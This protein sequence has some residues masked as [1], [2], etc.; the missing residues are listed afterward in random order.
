MEPE[1]VSPAVSELFDASMYTYYGCGS[2][3]NII[4][5]QK[6]PPVKRFHSQS[7][8]ANRVKIMSLK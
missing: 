1:A 7:L 8:R 5:R 3:T 6:M 4:L 2:D